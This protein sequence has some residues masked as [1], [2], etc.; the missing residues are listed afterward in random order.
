VQTFMGLWK[1]RHPNEGSVSC[2]DCMIVWP[3]IN[4]IDVETIWYCECEGSDSEAR[5]IN[6]YST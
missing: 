1:A 5:F 2:V 4:D 6:P 3:A